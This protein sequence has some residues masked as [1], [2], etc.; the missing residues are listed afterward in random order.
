MLVVDQATYRWTNSHSHHAE[1]AADG[2]PLYHDCTEHVTIRR[3]GTPGRLDVVFA[4]G[5]GRL[6]SN[7]ILHTGAAVRGDDYLN[8]N[9]PG[10]VRALLDEAL[11]RGWQPSAPGR[12]ELDG[13][14]LIDTPRFHRFRPDPV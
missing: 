4:S 7:G 10:V 13:W 8:L 6:V 9:R 2:T 14:T 12:A 5:P 11:G 3:D 1:L